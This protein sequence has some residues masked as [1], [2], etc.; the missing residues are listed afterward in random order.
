MLLR[1]RAAA[2]RDAEL[3]VHQLY[4][5]VSQQF[6]AED[7]RL[8]SVQLSEQRL[9]ADV[10]DEPDRV[11]AAVQERVQCGAA[12]HEFLGGNAGG[13]GLR[14]SGRLRAAAVQFGDHDGPPESGLFVQFDDV[15]VSIVDDLCTIIYLMDFIS[16]RT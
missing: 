10:P 6:A 3:H 12:R 5:G 7:V 13:H 2:E 15:F 16:V 11:R 14:L 9:D 8:H 4:D 1:C